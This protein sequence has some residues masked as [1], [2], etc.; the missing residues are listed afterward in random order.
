MALRAEERKG[1]IIGSICEQLA[2]RLPDDDHA[3]ADRFARHFYRD[4]A[5]SDLL[6]RD[7][8]DLYGAALALFRF[9]QER[10]PGAPKLRAYNPRLEQHGWQSAHTI[11]EIVN[12]DMPFLVDSVSM[13]LNRHGLGIHL[14]IHPT[15]AVRRDEAGRLVELGAGEAGNGLRESFMHVEIDRQS[16]PAVLAQLER[17]LFR[18][19]GDVRLAVQDWRQMRARIDEAREGLAAG[20]SHLAAEEL[21]EAEEFLRWLADDHFTFVGSSTYQLETDEAGE[22]QLRRIKGTGLGILRGHDD[23]ARSPS[24]AELPAEVR[25]Q[26]RQAEP[27]VALT[28]AKSRSTVHRA[29][30]LD[31]VGVKRFGPDGL[32][33]GEHRFLGLFTSAAYS[34]N[35][36]SIPLLRRKVALVEERSGFSPKGH[37]G[38]ALAHVLE[39]YPRDELLQTPTDQLLATVGEILH[40]QDRQKLRLFVRSDAY[41]RFASCL[42]YVPR[43]RYNTAFRERIQRLLEEALGGTESEFQAQLDESTLARLL[44]TIRTPSGMPADFDAEAL[45]RRLVEASQGWG[46]RLRAA[47]IETRGEEDGNRLFGRFGRAVPTSYAELVDPRLAV[48]DIT[49]LDRLTTAPTGAVSL[50]L[51]RRL[52]DR[53]DILRLKLFRRDTIVLLSEAL[54]ILENMGLKVLSEQPHE[55]RTA[56]GGTYYLHDFQLRP[57]T[58][59]GIDVDE[60]REV[61]AD[62]FVGVWTDAVENDG[63]NRLVL[64]ARLHG[65]RRHRSPRLLQVYP[66]DRHTLQPGLYRADP[67]LE[68]RARP[69]AGRAVPRPLRSR[70]SR[71]AARSGRG[72]WRSSSWPASTGS[73]AWTRT[74]SSAAT[75]A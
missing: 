46:E 62:A 20:A 27:L 22:T 32:V 13:E 26:A 74:A 33:V 49:Q 21:A 67:G 63:F 5:P 16:D 52:E 9:G 75:W 25:A 1:E 70:R 3:L 31:Y 50:S 38:K 45:E 66:A 29:T 57:L 11:V 2:S 34:L 72:R 53:P 55:I 6:E 17:D 23:G 69:P 60:L 35:P 42:V 18:V 64:L 56:D 7:Q 12:D 43:D 36:R 44:F 68:P 54:P 10:R 41:A 61:F 30:Y 40:L 47:L 48:P 15:F 8:L 19:L 59:D 65:P 4:V 28:K 24:F 51:Y 58:P 71:L 37:S 14:I 39:T 73:R